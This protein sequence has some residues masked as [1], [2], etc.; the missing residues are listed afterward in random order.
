[1][2][3]LSNI[4]MASFIVAVL[5][6]ITTILLGWNIYTLI[7]FKEKERMLENLR[8]EFSNALKVVQGTN[9]VINGYTQNEIAEV[10][11]SILKSNINPAKYLIQKTHAL[12]AYDSVS[13]ISSCRLIVSDILLYLQSD[14]G[15]NLEREV[16][17]EMY[18]MVHNIRNK[19][20]IGNFDEMTDQLLA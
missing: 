5:G 10:Y 19:D 12:I 3:Y 17:L 7:D 20:R 14:Y 6:L 9:K 11:L 13:D 8:N 4:D 2:V 16:R 18:K 15:K 1:M